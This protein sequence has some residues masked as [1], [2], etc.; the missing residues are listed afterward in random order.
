MSSATSGSQIIEAEVLDFL[1]RHDGLSAL[2]SACDLVRKC[3]PELASIHVRLLEDPDEENHTWVLIQ[4]FVPP[5]SPVEVLR[6]QQARYYDELKRRNPL[7]Y[8]PFSF[9][10]MLDTMQ[11]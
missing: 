10:L 5:S 3:F 7:P 6:E 11:D 1:G 4:V 9:S 2:E 8:H